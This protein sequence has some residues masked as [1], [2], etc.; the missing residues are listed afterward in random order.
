MSDNMDRTLEQIRRN[1]ETLKA[2]WQQAMRQVEGNRLAAQSLAKLKTIP[3]PPR[4]PIRWSSERQRKAYFASRGFG[5]GIPSRRTGEIVG[6]WQGEF[7]ATSDG[8]TLALINRNPAVQFLQ[9]ARV[10]GFHLDTGWVQ[11]DDVENDAHKEMGDI[12]VATFYE[13][14]DPFQGV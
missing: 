9:G 2:R 10:Q 1:F 5:R 12:A 3:G 8:G 11:I 13:V 4:Y 6:A 14:G 7:V